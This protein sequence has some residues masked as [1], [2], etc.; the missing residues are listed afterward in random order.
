M[1]TKLR[2]ELREEL[3]D[4]L[5]ILI[6]AHRQT[7]DALNRAIMSFE[8]QLMIKLQPVSPP[9]A[10]PALA[11]ETPLA[12][13]KNLCHECH[14][15]RV[16]GWCVNLT[17]ARFKGVL[18]ACRVQGC[19]TP[20]PFGLC[21][22]HHRQGNHCKVC[23]SRFTEDGFCPKCSPKI[24]CVVKDCPVPVYLRSSGFTIPLCAWHFEN[25]VR[26]C[27]DHKIALGGGSNAGGNSSENPCP[28]CVAT[29]AQMSTE[30]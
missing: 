24:P 10:T 30:K 13:W 9:P 6:R 25:K 23:G 19:E 15:A 5:Q 1:E 17:C 7:F 29:I 22:D 20:T 14:Q 18:S 12:S 2:E 27:V 11:P 4:E 16:R 26:V 28:K 8:E 21:R 3:R